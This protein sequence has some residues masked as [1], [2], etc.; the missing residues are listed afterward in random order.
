MSVHDF[1]NGQRHGYIG[2][3]NKHPIFENPTRSQL[4]AFDPERVYG[5]LTPDDRLFIWPA[6]HATH[7]A[8]VTALALNPITRIDLDMLPSGPAI[9][10]RISAHY[11]AMAAKVVEQSAALRVLYGQFEVNAGR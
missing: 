10:P 2:V 1:G 7:D 8:L 3:M 9:S 11:R 6:G 5:L 4:D